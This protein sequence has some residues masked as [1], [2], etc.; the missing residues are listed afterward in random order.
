MQGVISYQKDGIR[1]M[2]TIIRN[3]LAVLVGVVAGSIVNAGLVN[4]GPYVIA[5]PPGA[6]ISTMEGLSDSMPLFSPAN[7]LFPFLAHAL[8]TLTGAFIAARIA[9]S[10][11]LL[12]AMCIGLFFL[13]GGIAA[14]NMLGGPVWFI[15]ADLTLAYIP[16]AYLG[17]ILAGSA[18]PVQRRRD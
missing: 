8:G 7:F 3:I 15:A 14:A 11:H 5:L 4:L 16:M 18:Y 9:T 2:K 10:H 13:A 12:F 6:D 1:H 17:A